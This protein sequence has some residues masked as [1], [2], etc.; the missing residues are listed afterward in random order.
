MRALECLRCK[1]LIKTNVSRT[2]YC[3]DCRKLKWRLYR[4]TRN[5]ELSTNGKS[6]M[7]KYHQKYKE[8]LKS[9][10]FDV[11]G[12]VC[13]CCVEKNIS[14]LTIDHVNNDGYLDRRKKISGTSMYR[15]I[16]IE[17]FPTK[18]QILCMNCNWSKKI[19]GGICEHKTI[20]A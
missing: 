15:K 2:K 14:M 3:V 11:Y 4:K 17:K 9:I 12:W 7:Q 18:Y 8:R 5:W 1:T 6:Y 20:R 19:L 13:S 16:I 10:V